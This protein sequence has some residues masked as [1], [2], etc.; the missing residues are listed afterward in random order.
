MDDDLKQQLLRRLDEMGD[1]LALLERNQEFIANAVRR[2][3]IRRYWRRPPM[4]TFEQHLPRPLDLTT[5]PPASPLPADAPHIAMVTPSYNHARFLDATIDSI[6]GQNYPKLRYHMQDGAS[7]D[8]TTELL[9]RRGD[10]INWRSEPDHGQAHAI[11]LGFAGVDGD[12]MAYLNSDDMLLPGTLA[13]IVNFFSA[14]PDVDIVYG[15]RIFI[16]RDGLEVGRAVLPAHHGKT[17]Q[18]ADYIP[19]ETMFWRKRV[20]QALGS[21]DENF[22]YA[23]DWDFILRAQAVGFKFARLP[24]SRLLSHSRRAENRGDLR[25]RRQGDDGVTIAHAWLRAHADANPP[26]GCSVCRA[27][28]R[29]SL[30]LQAGPAQILAAGKGRLFYRRAAIFADHIVNWPERSYPSLLEPERLGTPTAAQIEIV[31][32][33]YQHARALDETSDPKLGLGHELRVACQN[34]FVHQ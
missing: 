32:R 4:W 24:V 9:K 16:D 3:A 10:T 33:Q 25:R 1:R 28:V 23:L 7:V 14:R 17:L 27:A 21:I 6:L 19:Q 13:H 22:H 18:Y 5:F 26:G 20:W 29:V 15:H 11:N 8:G 34:P 2:A 12:I 30:E 31:R